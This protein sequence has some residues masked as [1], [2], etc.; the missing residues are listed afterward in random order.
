MNSQEALQLITTK[1]A[2]AGFSVEGSPTGLC[3]V[4]GVIPLRFN[5]EGSTYGHKHVSNG[6]CR[7]TLGEYGKL[8][9]YPQTKDGEYNWP[10]MIGDIKERIAKEEAR[11]AHALKA[12]KLRDR[13]DVEIDQLNSKYGCTRGDVSK[14]ARVIMDSEGLTFS[15]RGL[16]KGQADALM[17]KAMELGL[18]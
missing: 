5:E 6:R 11:A 18:L 3:M 12:K 1:L 9:Q 14:P 7:V 10:K 2:D 13:L 16:T 4:N 8:T 17:A 15:A